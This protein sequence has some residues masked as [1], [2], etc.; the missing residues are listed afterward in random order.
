MKRSQKWIERQAEDV[1][2]I[3][4]FFQN[5]MADPFFPNTPMPA[6]SET[7]QQAQPS[8]PQPST[9]GAS[10]VRPAASTA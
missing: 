9:G 8:I 6:T 10:I 5:I 4:K 7:P 2:R 3:F 1:F